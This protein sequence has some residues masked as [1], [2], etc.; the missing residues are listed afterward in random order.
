[1]ESAG[2][3]S[4]NSSFCRNFTDNGSSSCRDRGLPGGLDEDDA[5]PVIIAII[6]TALYSIV[7]MV[8]LVGNLLVM[9]IIVRENSRSSRRLLTNDNLKAVKH[10]SVSLFISPSICGPLFGSQRSKHPQ[11][12]REQ[13]DLTN[14]AAG[15]IQMRLG[16]ERKR[17]PQ[18]IERGSRVL[19]V[20]METLGGDRRLR[21]EPNTSQSSCLHIPPAPRFSENRAP[22]P[23]SCWHGLSRRSRGLWFE[24]SLESWRAQCT[25][26]MGFSCLPF[27]VLRNSEASC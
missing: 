8:G 22:L 4:E 26:L 21:N 25:S 7:C 15:R 1:M 9:Y 3:M 14:R 2:N 19:P 11:S 10:L 18:G 27:C 17:V 12:C 23:S 16:T 5:N 13:T 24:A 6:I 20:A